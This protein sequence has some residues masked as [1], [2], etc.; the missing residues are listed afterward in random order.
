M[1]FLHNLSM[2]KKFSVV[3]VGFMIPI[4][5]LM[6]FFIQEAN[7]GIEFA[8]KEIEGDNFLRPLRGLLTQ[9]SYHRLYALR[10]AN[11]DR[12]AQELLSKTAANITSLLKEMRQQDERYNASLQIGGRAAK[13]ENMWKILSDK[14]PTLTPDQSKSEHD[15]LVAEVRSLIVWVGDKS[16]LILDP[17]LDSYYIM[18]AVLIRLMDDVDLVHQSV[19]GMERTL[20]S[21]LASPNDRSDAK[22]LLVLMSAHTVGLEGDFATAYDN[23]PLGNLK[24]KLNA[25]L[26][27]HIANK[28]EY[29]NATQEKFIMTDFT[30]LTIAD[31]EAVASAYIRT[32]DALW[33]NSVNELDALL[34]ARIEGFRSKLMINVVVVA[35]ILVLIMLIVRSIL[36]DIKSSVTNLVE[37]T[38]RV[39]SGDMA[40]Q[41]SITGNDEF[42]ALAS[43][44][45][46]MI[47]RIKTGVGELR[48]EK[49]TIQKRVEEAVHDS[50]IQRSY[51]AKSTQ[52]LLKEMEQFAHGD[53]TVQL[54]H[55]RKD[56][57]GAL[58]EGFT[59]AASNLRNTVE[60][61]YEA[62]NA[63]VSASTQIAASSNQISAGAR[64]QHEEISSIV[65]AIAEMSQSIND[66]SR[67]VVM[68]SNSAQ[69]AGNLAEKSGEVLASTAKDIT[70]VASI[71][72]ASAKT[73]RQLGSQSQEIGEIIQVIDEIADQTNLL[74]LNA[75]IEA[76]RAGEQGK[77]FAVVADEVRKL[78]ER[79]TK[80]TKR[81]TEMIEHIQASTE[82]AVQT[83]QR[84][85]S[86]VRRGKES[87]DRAQFTVSG[88]VERSRG[89][90]DAILQV[91]AATEEQSQAS[92]EVLRNAETI[93]AITE[94][95]SAGIIQIVHAVEDVSKLAVHLEAIVRQFNIGAVS[96][97]KHQNNSLK[98]SASP[99]SIGTTYSSPNLLV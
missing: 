37:T 30:Q 75:A 88:I 47:D 35:G 57:I 79:T 62:V 76:A 77:G 34:Y 17:D 83:I 64:R 52:V 96:Q 55:D 13:I 5:L 86:E 53:L 36:G 1:T 22:V 28:R 14:L 9:S 19:F 51:L 43:S 69:D 44:I 58:F 67:L 80:A 45:N 85:I 15:A 66:N 60:K 31:L 4:V 98:T 72:E 27:K 48:A 33:Y 81:I 18:D 59:T 99:P 40:A 21:G 41:S 97:G 7:K 73:V 93:K 78:A 49:S 90:A 54:H 42:A 23:N 32:S 94:S 29:A 50:E 61:V 24:P 92:E 39:K 11:N 46:S 25:E 38:N 65:S 95:T 26:R 20:R 68:V 6:F 91:A 87:A 10:T 16:N 74:A 8:Q 84:G 63:T 3:I 82:E 71:V 12:E 2:T 89:V 56:D 70:N